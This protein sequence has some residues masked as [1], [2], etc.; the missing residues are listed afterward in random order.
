M[1]L[2]TGGHG[3]IG[4]NLCIKLSTNN[5]PFRVLDLKSAKYPWSLDA[6]YADVTHPI[7][8]VFGHV[9]VHLAAETNVRYSL[10]HP[11]RVVT[12][13]VLGLM[14]CL[15]LL[16]AESF[17]HLVFTSSA[18]SE[19]SKNPYLASKLA[20]ESLCKAYRETYG[21]DVVVLK[22]S[23]VYG[24]HST[25]KNSVIHAFIKR[26]INGEP[27]V[28]FGDGSQKRDF[29]FV[30]DVVD[31]I[32]QRKDGF[33]TTGRL[34]SIKYIATMIS[35]MSKELIGYKPTIVYEGFIDGE[36][37]EASDVKS[38]MTKTVDIETGIYN[39]FQ[40]YKRNYESQRLV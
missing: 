31:A 14:N 10:A 34:T 36:V 30:D 9:I 3:F 40:W 16:R 15:D 2:I 33:I 23:S 6:L 22:F 25:H 8:Y 13:N 21:I 7:P 1:C 17:K 28:I 20:C 29:I 27:I 19:Q 12:R 32:I 39:T 38:D 37:R 4:T 11:R 35:S 18:S 26:C 24:P 5:K